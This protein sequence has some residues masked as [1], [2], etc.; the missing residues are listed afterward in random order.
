MRI[1]AIGTNDLT[2]FNGVGRS[3]VAV[4]A[5]FLVAGI[6]NLGLRLFDTNLI[7]R[8]MHYVAIVTGHIINLMLRSVPVRP[9]SPFMAGLA[10]IHTIGT[11]TL[12]VNTLLEYKIRGWATFAFITTQVGS[13]LAVARRTRWRTGIPFYAMLGLVDR[14]N[15][16]VLA[17][18]VA[19]GANGVFFK[20]VFCNI[21][22]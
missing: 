22:F 7:N 14:E 10:L 21:G 17:F 1:V 18:I 13:A 5:L 2:N 16:G 19:L 4:C 8:V 11:G 15:G 3:L 12:V 20:R 6:A 9:C